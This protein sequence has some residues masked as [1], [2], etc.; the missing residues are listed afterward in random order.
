MSIP[1]IYWPTSTLTLA[2][3]YVLHDLQ[4]E[5]LTQRNESFGL[6]RCQIHQRSGHQLVKEVS[7]LVYHIVQR[8]RYR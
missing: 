2:C 8:N 4:F 6:L 1:E 5:G 3:E 7:S